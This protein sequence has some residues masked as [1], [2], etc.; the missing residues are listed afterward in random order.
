VVYAVAVSIGS[1]AGGE[2]GNEKETR[3]IGLNP[4]LAKFSLHVNPHKDLVHKK[5]QSTT[6]LWLQR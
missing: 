6:E 3:R 5:L 4:L 1:S 2:V